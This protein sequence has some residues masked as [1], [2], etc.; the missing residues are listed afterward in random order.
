MI[1][2]RGN[3]VP[4]NFVPAAAAKRGGLALFIITGRKGQEDGFI[5]LQA[6]TE[7][8]LEVQVILFS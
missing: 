8:M 5:S 6:R 7:F 4:A 2:L 1:V 3:T